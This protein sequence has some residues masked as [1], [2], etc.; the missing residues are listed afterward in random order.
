MTTGE[1]TSRIHQGRALFSNP[2]RG[3]LKYVDRDCFIPYRIGRRGGETLAVHLS[4]TKSELCS[5][6]RH[7]GD[8]DH[9]ML[10]PTA[11]GIPS[12]TINKHPHSD[13]SPASVA[14]QIQVTKAS[15]IYR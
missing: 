7:G 9:L 15:D 2:H 14:G 1:T 4:L 6:G 11:F 10:G 5:V 12:T 8:P 13:K 3:D